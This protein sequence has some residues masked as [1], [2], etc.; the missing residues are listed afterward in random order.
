MFMHRLALFT[1]L[2]LMLFSCGND[3]KK[4]K[5]TEGKYSFEGFTAG[6]KEVKLPYQ[7]SDSGLLANKDTSKLTAIEFTSLIPDSLKV[8]YFGKA[9]L[10]YSPLAKLNSPAAETYLLVRA[11][12]GTKKAALL[13]VYDKDGNH[14]A[15]FPFLVP[16][17]DPATTQVSMIEKAYVIT[18]MVNKKTSEGSLDGKD[19]YSYDANTKSFNVIMTDPL[20]ESTVLINP[21]DTLPRSNKYSGDYVSGKNSL[22]S[23]RDGR[24]S[25]QIMAFVHFSKNEGSC[26]GELK[27][28][29]FFTSS[30]TAVYRVGGDPCIIEF[31]FKGSSVTLKEETGCGNK[32]GVDCLFDGTFTKKKPAA[33]KK[34]KK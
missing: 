24:T 9:R 4:K 5:D 30:T 14:A 19:V 16:D 32:R 15:T 6:F 27:G 10:R 31:V 18:K 33:S 20:E 26:E 12:A 13:V 1:I 17:N 11:A 2:V 34:R 28:E 7:L 25:K 21:I 3:D 23:I 8:K 29:L 22:V